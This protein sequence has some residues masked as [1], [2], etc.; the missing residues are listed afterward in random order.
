MV[1]DMS[2]VF[3]TG[4]VKNTGYAIAEKFARNGYDVAI[5][6]RN[7]EDLDAA[8]NKLKADYNVKVKGYVLNLTDVEQIKRVFFNIEQEFGRLDVFVANAANVGIDCDMQKITEDYYNDIMDVNL[9]G[10]YFC[11]QQA[12]LIM[13][14]YKCGSIVI[15]SSVHSKACTW[16]RSLYAASKGALNALMRSMAIELATY[17]IRTNCIIAGA[18]RT[19]RWNVL[20]AEQIEA[21]RQNWPVGKEATGE[22]I[23]N[24]VFYLGTDLS[25]VVSGTELTV[26]SGILAT[27][28]PYQGGRH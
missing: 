15:I 8:V 28:L 1:S 27:L 14:K 13:C 23:A 6:S 19:E 22:D 16:G 7:Q 17:G 18:I 26:D 20:T 12:A 25:K 3:I 10:T 2:C 9:K 4:A 24:G 21:K 11:C 5:S